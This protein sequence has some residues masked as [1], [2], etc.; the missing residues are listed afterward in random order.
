MDYLECYMYVSYF[1]SASKNAVMYA[2][3]CTNIFDSR[4]SAVWKLMRLSHSSNPFWPAHSLYSNPLLAL[5]SSIG[6]I[7]Y[8]CLLIY[9]ARPSR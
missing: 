9:Y 7:N 4:K 6:S 8:A 2:T 5:F 1:I 3:L